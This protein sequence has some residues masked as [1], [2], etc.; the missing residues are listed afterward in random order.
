MGKNPQD[1][2]A[3]K[4]KTP[5]DPEPRQVHSEEKRPNLLSQ[6]SSHGQW[7]CRTRLSAP[8]RSPYTP[9]SGATYAW[10]GGHRSACESPGY[11]PGIAPRRRGAPRR[12]CH[13][14]GDQ[15]CPHRSPDPAPRRTP[16]VG[17][18]RGEAGKLRASDA[19][20]GIAHQRLPDACAAPWSR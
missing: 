8:W 13:P 7:A 6:C 4:H 1:L 11:R 9:G 17:V 15:P 2:K 3:S 5:N 14:V 18:I 12:R 10:P 19:P 20:A 16:R